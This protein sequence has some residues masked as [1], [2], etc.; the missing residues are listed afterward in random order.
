MY[1]DQMNEQNKNAAIW[2]PDSNLSKDEHLSSLLIFN[3]FS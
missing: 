2:T 3:T 1:T